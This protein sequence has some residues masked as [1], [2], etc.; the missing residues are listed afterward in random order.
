MEKNIKPSLGYLALAISILMLLSPFLIFAD[1]SNL[2]IIT[3][4]IVLSFLSIFGFI[5]LFVVNPNES[6]VLILFGKYFYHFTLANGWATFFELLVLSF[7]GLVVFIGFG[8]IISSV[9]K[10]Q[11][12]IP[13]YANLFLFPQYF[14]S[15]TFFPKTALP[16]GIQSVINYL[17]LTALNDAMRKVSF[18]GLHLS[19]VISELGILAAWCVVTYAILIRVFKW[20]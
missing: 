18:E 19:G 16:A 1:E 7:F 17:P 11:N 13:I 8:F 5:G 2:L 6:M 10:N 4:T 9:S 12:V 3:G 20:E 15:G 14:L